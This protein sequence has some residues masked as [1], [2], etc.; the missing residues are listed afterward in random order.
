[1]SE[2]ANMHYADFCKLLV[3]RNSSGEK[4][5]MSEVGFEP[6]LLGETTTCTP[7][8]AAAT[9]QLFTMLEDD[10]QSNPWLQHSP[11][12][13]LYPAPTFDQSWRRNVGRS[14]AKSEWS[15]VKLRGLA[16]TSVVFRSGV[17]GEWQ[18]QQKSD[19]KSNDEYIYHTA[20][21]IKTTSKK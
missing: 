7:A 2:T 13:R 15:R 6:T 16:V 18:W 20:V 3:R 21:H 8:A 17:W 10:G 9:V 4:H 1:M 14:R 19:N 11:T 5:C 12:N